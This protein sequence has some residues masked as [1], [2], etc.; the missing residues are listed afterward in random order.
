VDVTGNLVLTFTPDAVVSADD[1]AVQFSSGGR[2]ASF[3]ITSGQTAAI[4]TDP[5]LAV[6]TGTVAGTITMTATL[7]ANGTPVTCSCTLVKTIRI[8]RSAPVITSVTA[9]K[10]VGGFTITIIGYSSSRELTNASFHFNAGSA[11]NLR[12]TDVTV[13]VGP[14]FTTWFQSGQSVQF[15]SQFLL[16]QPFVVTGDSNAAASVAV[17][18]TNSVGSSTAVTANIQ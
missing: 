5:N 1:P 7:Q 16:T 10:N 2:T 13:P 14:V 15:G 9:T 11:G 12:T 4:F 8:A 17:T 18:L 6:Q 3:R